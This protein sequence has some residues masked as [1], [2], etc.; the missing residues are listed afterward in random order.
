M[1]KLVVVSLLLLFLFQGKYRVEP[2]SIL[3]SAQPPIAEMC[4]QCVSWDLE[5]LTTMLMVGRD[6]TL[7]QARPEEVQWEERGGAQLLTQE[8]DFT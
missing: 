3:S 5:P 1:Q 7:D 8:V 4:C 2:Q 6:L